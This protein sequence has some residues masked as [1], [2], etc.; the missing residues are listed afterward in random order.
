M[1]NNSNVGIY[2]YKLY[3][4][5][6]NQTKA[7]RIE[8]EMESASATKVDCA[9]QNLSGVIPNLNKLLSPVVGVAFNMQP[10]HGGINLKKIKTT[11]SGLW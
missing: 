11:S 1:V 7:K 3:K 10:K 4:I 2:A 5:V 9:V 6:N 8:D